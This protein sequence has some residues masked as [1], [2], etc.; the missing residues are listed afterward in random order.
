MN[1][2]IMRKIKFLTVIG[3]LLCSVTLI[4]YGQQDGQHTTQKMAAKVATINQIN[5]SLSSGI[6]ST[7]PATTTATTVQGTSVTHPNANG[8][9]QTRDNA[10]KDPA[11]ITLQK[12]VSKSLTVVPDVVSNAAANRTQATKAQ[13][14][15]A[16]I[17][18]LNNNVNIG[19]VKAKIN[20]LN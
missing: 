18:A 15:A 12:K 14:K 19:D 1:L 13:R 5:G 7:T 16:R 10:T 2:N 4:S 9:F 17:Q 20:K 6:N 3:V 11:T 8:T